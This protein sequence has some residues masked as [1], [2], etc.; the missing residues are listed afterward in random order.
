MFRQFSLFV[1]PIFFYRISYC[2]FFKYLRE[3]IF[4]QT[5]SS[6]GM[7][8]NAN[9]NICTCSGCELATSDRF[10]DTAGNFTSMSPHPPQPSARCFNDGH[11][12]IASLSFHEVGYVASWTPIDGVYIG[13]IIR[14]KEISLPP[15]R[16]LLP[17]FNPVRLLQSR[18][19]VLNL[20]LA[21]LKLAIIRLCSGSVSRS[22]I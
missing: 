2:R 5:F 15:I 13:C 17:S 19:V 20:F 10:E 18:F 21:C 11:A 14:Q 3:P 9:G 4:S 7:Y 8:C 6:V 22:V 12:V 16:F 1:K